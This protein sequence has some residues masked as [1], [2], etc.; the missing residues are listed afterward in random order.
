MPREAVR[1]LCLFSPHE[2]MSLPESRL[3]SLPFACDWTVGDITKKVGDMLFGNKK[4][5][6]K[7]E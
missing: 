1:A 3:Q 2:L 5:P 7:K 6:K 4:V